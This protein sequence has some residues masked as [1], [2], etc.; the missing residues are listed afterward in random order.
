ML[1]YFE[2]NLTHLIDH[3][4]IFIAF[5]NFYYSPCVKFISLQLDYTKFASIM[6][7]Q[8]SNS[9]SSPSSSSESDLDL[10]PIIGGAVGGFAGLVLIGIA[11][12]YFFK[13]KDTGKVQVYLKNDSLA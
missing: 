12:Y 13:R 4:C 6:M 10:A 1:S 5:I 3:W 11:C 8:P 7:A 9:P 2:K